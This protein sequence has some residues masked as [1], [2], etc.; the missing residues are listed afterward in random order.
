MQRLREQLAADPNLYRRKLGVSVAL[1]EMLRR[2]KS[3]GAQ[4]KLTNDDI[5]LLLDFAGSDDRTLRIYAGE[6]LFDFGN[7]DVTRLALPRA[8]TA[9]NDDARFNWVFVSQGGWLLFSDS[10]KKEF[11]KYI[12]AIRGATKDKPKTADLLAVFK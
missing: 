2:D 11:S 1:V 10:E 3:L 5:N 8:A 7:P 6:F 9:T 12:D 4:I